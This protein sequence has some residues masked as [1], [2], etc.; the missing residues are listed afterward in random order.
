MMNAI[1]FDV[2][3]LMASENDLY[4]ICKSMQKLSIFD[5]YGNE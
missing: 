2:F 1:G 5:W 3:M 4:N